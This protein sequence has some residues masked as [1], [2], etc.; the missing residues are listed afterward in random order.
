MFGSSPLH[1]HSSRI[2]GSGSIIARSCANGSCGTELRDL[3]RFRTESL[4]SLQM[5]QRADP[6]G[7]CALFSFLNFDVTC[8]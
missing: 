5:A 8:N 2:R 7:S 3:K 4:D 1:N 6:D